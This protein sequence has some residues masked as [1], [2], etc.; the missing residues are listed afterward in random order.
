MLRA[1]WARGCGEERTWS[2][3]RGHGPGLQVLG[4]ERAQRL[5]SHQRHHESI[6]TGGGQD[7]GQDRG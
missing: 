4:D 3:Q 5:A 7:G 1:K 2:G 6:L